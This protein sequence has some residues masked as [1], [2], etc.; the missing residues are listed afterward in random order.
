MRRQGNPEPERP[1]APAVRVTL[2]VDTHADVH[3]GVALDHLGRRLGSRAV[4]TTPAGYAEL[5]AWARPFGTLEGNCGTGGASLS[6][7]SSRG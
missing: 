1:D 6:S 3:V 7:S 5:V 2:G 4:P